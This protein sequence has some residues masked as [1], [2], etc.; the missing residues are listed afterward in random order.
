MKRNQFLKHL[1]SIIA[2]TLFIV[3]TIGSDGGE[4]TTVSL[5]AQVSFNGSQFVIVNKDN[6][7]YR[8]AKLELNGKSLLST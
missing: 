3:L 8:N 7:D 5:N 2:I 4:D 1:S 6:F